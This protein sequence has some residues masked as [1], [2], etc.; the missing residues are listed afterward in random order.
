MQAHVLEDTD[1]IGSWKSS[2]IGVRRDKDPLVCMIT[3]LR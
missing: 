1:I 2:P 3:G